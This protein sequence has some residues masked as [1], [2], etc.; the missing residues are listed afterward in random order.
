MVTMKVIYL[1]IPAIWI[2]LLGF[3]FFRRGL[4]ARLM[5][6]IL[7]LL[8]VFAIVYPNYADRPVRTEHVSK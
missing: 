7:I 3:L 6:W 5:F 4:C 2:V 8:A 1:L